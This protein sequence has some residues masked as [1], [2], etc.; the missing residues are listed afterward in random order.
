MA[1]TPDNLDQIRI[2]AAA[3]RIAQEIAEEADNPEFRPGDHDAM[4]AL[5]ELFGF[6]VGREAD[7]VPAELAGIVAR[8]ADGIVRA[9]LDMTEQSEQYKAEQAQ[10]EEKRKAAEALRAADGYTVMV[11][12][13]DGTIV[14]V[15]PY[16]FQFQAEGAAA[17]FRGC[18]HN[19]AGAKDARIEVLPYDETIRHRAG[20][21]PLDASSLMYLIQTD[22][23]APGVSP[24]DFPDLYAR[25]VALHGDPARDA[26]RKACS[27]LDAETED[28]DADADV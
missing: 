9:D 8:L 3:D 5:H 19:T 4:T 15:G 26:W 20:M 17:Y 14:R 22:E 7:L 13:A 28:A 27:Y 25:L 24:G 10:R 1:E 2:K 16:A 23:Q 6:C 18:G 21:V 11:T 12:R